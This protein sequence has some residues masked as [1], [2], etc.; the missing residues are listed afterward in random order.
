MSK[1]WSKLLSIALALAVFCLPATAYAEGGDA[2][3]VGGVNYATVQEAINAADGKTVT[4]LKNV[5]ESVN[6]PSGVEM[7]LDLAGFT[8]TNAANQHTITNKGVLTITG[9]GTVDNVSHGKGALVNQG[10]VRMNGGTL[11]R[12]QEKG[13]SPT[14]SGGNSWYVVDNNGG[15]FT[16]TGGKIVNTSGFSS[17]IRNLNATFTLENGELEN[18]FIVLKNDDQGVVD[19]SGGTV[20]TTGEGG[21]AVQNWG[22]LTVSGGTLNASEEG[23]A[24]FTL[25]WKDEYVSKATILDGATV[26]GD[27]Q[28]N[29]D[30]NYANSVTIVPSLEIKGGTVDGDISV[31]TKS[32]LTVSGGAVTGAIV[33]ND[34][35][36]DVGITGGSFAVKPR[37]SYIDSAATVAK[38]TAGTADTF[39]IGDAEQ[40]QAKL[41]GAAKGDKIE[42]LQGSAALTVP[43][44]VTVSN[45]GTGSVTANGSAVEKDASVVTHTHQA[46]KVAAKAPGAAQAGNIEYWY[47]AGCGKYFKDEALKQEITLQ[48]TVL[49]A[50]G[51]DENSELPPTGGE[52]GVWALIVLTGLAGATMCAAL[53]ARKKKFD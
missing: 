37:D 20:T 15:A 12:S 24:I 43:D 6:V 48:D 10:T 29:V 30:P 14:N 18:G 35:T 3:A 23:V 22:Q 33:S 25:T 31:N 13:S 16:M 19:M 9:A 50:T 41:S 47:C 26:N 7:T 1:K 28:M 52:N 11:T 49:A 45:S 36:G 5:T 51:E 17:L 4:L 21:S 44:G 53:C 42:I 46:T 8:L 40:V 39:L 27:I 2:A 38:Y 32:E 34:D